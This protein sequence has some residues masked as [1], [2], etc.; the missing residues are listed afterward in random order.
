MDANLLPIR[1]RLDDCD[2]DIEGVRVMIA[3]QVS[4]W[5]SDEKMKP[6][7]RPATLFNATKFRQYYDDRNQPTPAPGNGNGCG[8]RARTPAQERNRFISDHDEWTKRAAAR[9]ER[10][11]GEGF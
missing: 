10:M 4:L 9:I 2:G 3:R 1:C 7:L 6:Y 5:G 8:S 11:E